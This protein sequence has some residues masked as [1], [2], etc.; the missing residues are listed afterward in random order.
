MHP[1]L[2]HA[3]P[4]VMVVLLTAVILIDL[5]TTASDS[6]LSDHAEGTFKHL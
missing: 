1:L 3:V 5:E 4:A 6:N 2:Y